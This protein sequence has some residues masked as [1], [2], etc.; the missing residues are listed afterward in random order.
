MAI[1][2]INENSEKFS[3]I[4]GTLKLEFW[5]NLF[6]SEKICNYEIKNRNAVAKILSRIDY[7]IIC[8][9]PFVEKYGNLLFSR[10]EFD[11]FDLQI[12]HL[13]LFA[14]DAAN[15]R[16]EEIRTKLLKCKDIDPK[17][18]SHFSL[19][20]IYPE[21]MPFYQGLDEDLR[22]LDESQIPYPV[23]TSEV[24]LKY[25]PYYISNYKK[26]TKEFHRSDYDNAKIIQ[27][28]KVLLNKHIIM[29]SDLMKDEYSDFVNQF[30]YVVL[31]D[32]PLSPLEAY[33]DK[34]P[35]SNNFMFSLFK[36]DASKL[37]KFDIIIDEQYLKV[38]HFAKHP[39]N[40]SLIHI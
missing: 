23:K 1:S 26:K 24:F 29:E 7:R 8:Y 17:L 35:V 33:L 25:L 10:P 9:S 22:I 2:I 37:K 12:L 20:K 30:I 21:K 32:E 14:N 11:N 18:L 28:I 4:P 6:N 13:S 3:D 5:Q 31:A 36:A 40:L 19:Q 34:S 27:R 38:L 16:T 39:L 15:Y